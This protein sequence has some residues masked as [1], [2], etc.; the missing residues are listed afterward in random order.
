MTKT[1]TYELEG[2]ALKRFTAATDGLQALIR[3]T[4]ENVWN[5]GRRLTV[6]HEVL[7][8]KFETF[9][10]AEGISIR[11]A[12][13]YIS[14]HKAWPT[15][16]AFKKE[17]LVKG[18]D[19]DHGITVLFARAH[20]IK[21][22]REQAAATSAAANGTPA[23]KRGRGRPAG[24]GSTKLAVNGTGRAH[25]RPAAPIPEI[26]TGPRDNVKV[27]GDTR[28]FIAISPISLATTGNQNLEASIWSDGLKAFNKIF[29]DTDGKGVTAF[30]GSLDKRETKRL[31]NE[32]GKL[33]DKAKNWVD[34][35]EG[36]P[37]LAHQTALHEAGKK[38]GSVTVFSG[39]KG[40]SG[41]QQSPAS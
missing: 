9:V 19:G 29:P 28:G 3:K 26:A 17:V 21:A 16:A 5:I 7:G 14:V 31:S 10:A 1:E 39:P 40:P 22:E 37:D 23:P 38:G 15:P 20:K 18:I 34:M 4:N 41:V 6:I 30:L 33:H 25:A 36:G 27:N 12:Y 13:N 35:L 2:K 24:S 32:L 11:T 8:G